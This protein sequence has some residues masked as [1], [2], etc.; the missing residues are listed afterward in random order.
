MSSVFKNVQI[1]MKN[2]LKYSKISPT[3]QK[4]LSI[5]KNRIQFSFPVALSQGTEIFEGYR[6]QHNNWLGPFKGGLRFH[7]QVNLD[8]VDALASWMTY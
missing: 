5:P 4:I 7:P 1:Q 3:T 8:E 2:A 6:V